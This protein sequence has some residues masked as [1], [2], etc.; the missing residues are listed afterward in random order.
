MKAFLKKTFKQITETTKKHPIWVAALI[1]ASVVFI[2]SIVRIAVLITPPKDN[3]EKYKYNNNYNNSQ[4]AQTQSQ[5]ADDN[6]VINFDLLKK[7]NPD[8]C[9]WITVEGT[10]IDYPIFRSGDDKAEDFYLDHKMNGEKHKDGSIYIQKCNAADFSDPNTL[11]Y[12]HNLLNGTKFAALKKFR[13]SQFFKQNR[14]ITVYTPDRTLEYEIFSAFIYDSRH[15][16][17]SFNFYDKA[18]YENFIKECLEPKSKVKNVLNDAS[19]NFGDKL[20]TLSTCTS[21][22]DERYLVV[23]VLTNENA[24]EQ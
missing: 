4:T 20:I 12:G 10:N 8:I 1:I 14:K 3:Y 17:N 24:Y 2:A 19:I 7:E 23:G 21:K 11:V 18:G 22:E 5:T 9:G 15:I 13:N 16:L 6:K